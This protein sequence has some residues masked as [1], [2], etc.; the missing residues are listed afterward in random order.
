MMAKTLV[1]IPT[2][3]EEVAIGSVVL[4]ARQYANEV[5]V[6]DDGSEDETRSVAELAMATV[7][8]HRRNL[9]KGA[10]I[11]TAFDYAQR[12]GHEVL[13]LIDGD[14]QHNP[15][16]IPRLVAPILDGEAD[17]VVGCRW[18]KADRMP[19]YRRAGKQT[20]DYMT[21]AFSGILTDSQSG[22]RAFSQ[23]AMDSL[24]ISSN[25]FGVESEIL[26]RAREAGL[27][28]TG[29][30][31]NSRYDVEGS[32]LGPVEH[33]LQV[34][35]AILRVVAEQHPLFFFSFPGLILFLLGLFVGFTTMETYNQTRTLAIG[36][37]LLAVILLILGSLGVFAGL[38]LNALPRALTEYLSRRA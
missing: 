16:E 33:G 6:V 4:R 12:N 19:L 7:L 34:V 30:P 10:A 37:T 18:G 14:G 11:R 31:I 24:D 27:K 8:S 9:G 15:D 29:V 3:N 13:V 38:I 32:T 1:A 28:I 23:K 25:G 20:L 35:D 26:M 22:L 36:Y 21:A 17:V 2:Y 5:L